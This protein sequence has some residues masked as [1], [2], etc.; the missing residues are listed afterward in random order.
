MSPSTCTTSDQLQL[1]YQYYQPGDLVIGGI[2]SQLFSVVDAVSFKEHPKTKLVQEAVAIPKNY[3]HVLSLV[4]AVKEINEN[5]KIL[6]NVTFGFHIYDSHF[7]A[8]MTYRNTLN[9]LFSQSRTVVNYS[10]DGRRIPVAVIGG[11]DS[12]ISLYMDM[13]LSIYKIPQVTYCSFAPIENEI[14]QLSSLYRMVPNEEYQYT[15]IVKLL[16]HFQWKWVGIIVQ[17]DEKG[18]KFGETLAHMFSQRG[19]CTAFTERT[20][21]QGNMFE[22]VNLLD[23]FLNLTIFLSESS[24]NICVVR[25]D[26]HT[27]LGV[28]LVLNLFESG[29]MKPIH[30]VWVMTAHWDFST[31]TFHRG[32][33]VQMFH[34]ALSFASKTSEVQG[35]TSFL[36]T[37]NP[38]SDV[39]GFIKDFWEQAFN[40]SFPGTDEHQENKEACNGEE[41]LENL[42]HPFFEMSVTGQSYSI[43]NAVYAVAHALHSM[44]S[45]TANHRAMAGGDRL[46]PPRMPHLQLHPFLRSISFNNTAGDEVSFD[47]KGE[48]A[49]G[50]D[51]VN[52]ITFP[53]KSFTKV[54]VGRMDP[55]SPPGREFF[56]DETLIT[57]YSSF[58]QTYPNVFDMDDCFNCPEDQYPNKER[59]QCLSKKLHFLSYDEFLANSWV[60]LAVS[61]SLT[62]AFVLGIFIKYQNTPIVKANN[63][64]L[65]YCL[66]VSLFLCSLLFIGHPTIQTCQLRQTAFGIIFSMAVSSILAKTITVVL[67]FMATK[68]DSMLR[69]W[70]GNRFANSIVLCCSCIQARISMVWLCTD[71]PFPDVDMHSLPQEIVVECNEGSS[72]MFYYILGY[73]GILALISF[74]VAFFARKLPDSFN[75]AKFITFSMLV[76]CSVWLS[77]V[78]AYLSTKGKYMVAVEIFSILASSAGL[79]VCIFSPKVYII[80]LRPELNCKEQLIRGNK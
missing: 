69:R 53:N 12:E 1:Q 49:A 72:N 77:F 24:V 46:Q 44:G 38:H 66:L 36:H 27:M 37:L 6:P 41:K 75:E 34:G 7:D 14:T 25:A 67:A 13:I 47:E 21:T 78:P 79:L 16:L 62:T 2:T 43:Y 59:N 76:F 35:F 8:R 28:Q 80:I 73:Q 29:T 70:V 3:Q 74:V 32:L 51:I 5:P 17:R 15:G 42:P 40:C 52:W 39:D 58:N 30:K 10:C 9:L 4:F 71:P 33:D 19:I 23:T 22:L 18:E 60:I 68:P 65:T 57:W 50:F 64:N 55:H 48:L 31:A 61:L 26:T 45:S 20:P 56:I 11:L 63:R 54:K